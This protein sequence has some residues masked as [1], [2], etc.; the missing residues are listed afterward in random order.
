MSHEIRTPMNG[1]IGMA[2]LVLKTN[3]SDRQRHYLETVGNLAND[4]LEIVSDILDFSKIESRQ[5]QLDYNPFDIREVISRA[6]NPQA[7]RAQA[8]KLEFH[9][10]IAPDVPPWVAGDAGHLRQ[11]LV[12]LVGNAI[13]FTRQGGIIVEARKAATENPDPTRVMIRLSV[14]DSGSGI[15]ADKRELIF[16][17]FT[18]ADSS[19]SRHYGGTGLGLAICRSLTEAMGGRIWLE[20]PD[21]TGSR[22][23]FEV[24]F[25]LYAAPA[26]QPVD[27]ELQRL[28]GRRTLL[29]AHSAATR[30]I[31]SEML[32][33]WGL[34]VESVADTMVALET[35]SS[36]AGSAEPISALIVEAEMPGVSGWEL[37]ANI[38]RMTGVQL[39]V[40]LLAD[41]TAAS[42]SQILRREEIEFCS[43]PNPPSHSQLKTELI[44]LLDESAPAEPAAEP[45]PA[46]LRPLSILLAEDN[47]VNREVAVDML[48]AL[49]HTVVTAD[50]GREAVAAWRAGEFDVILMDVHMPDM[51]GMEATRAIRRSETH[52]DRV[53]PIIA[54]TANNT[55]EQRDQCLANGMTN[56]LAKPIHEHALAQILMP[57]QNTVPVSPRRRPAR[58]ADMKPELFTRLA[59]LFV[60]EGP[61]LLDGLEDAVEQ[62]DCRAATQLAHKLKGSL[63]QFDAERARLFADDL[64][65]AARRSELDDAPALL[66]CLKRE[67][68]ELCDSL[69]DH[70]A[71]QS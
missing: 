22:F 68:A 37:A 61:A 19:I 54:I 59:G 62:G 58:K 53:T 39:P 69:R 51:D 66:R 57:I 1:I 13:K 32:D 43:I 26:R 55:A 63:V 24:P 46:T 31:V 60:T 8:K 21:T 16:Q 38:R 42:Q 64:E 40:V 4:L 7:A 56:Y 70:L 67:M 9:V 27:V 11:V 36:A 10:R 52:A 33:S 71:N 18:Q 17:R 65:T 12:N 25:D 45:K 50:N 3:L 49:G 2:E 15:P 14:T 47:A 28:A 35:I 6:V 44:R 20:Q 34:D 23:V 5:I 41:L 30:S 48:E 29:V